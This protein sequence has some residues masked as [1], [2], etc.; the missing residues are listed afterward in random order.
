MQVLAVIGWMLGI[1]YRGM[2]MFLVAFGAT[3]NRMTG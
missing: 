3:I 2:A 1:S